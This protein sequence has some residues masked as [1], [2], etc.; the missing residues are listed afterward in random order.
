MASTW[1]FTTVD[2]P[3]S[4]NPPNTFILGVS[5]AGTLLGDNIYGFPTYGRSVFVGT[6]NGGFTTPPSDTL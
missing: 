1:Q 3:E 5:D 6:P 2:N 4:T